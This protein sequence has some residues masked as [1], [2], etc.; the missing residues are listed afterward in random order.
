MLGVTIVLW[1]IVELLSTQG[2]N[3]NKLLPGITKSERL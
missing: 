2:I 1:G 3:F